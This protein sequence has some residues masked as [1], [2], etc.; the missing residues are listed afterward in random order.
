ML[1]EMGRDLELSKDEGEQLRKKF[2]KL[3]HQNNNY[4]D[5]MKY[6]QQLST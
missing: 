5:K 2:N 4:E 1:E 6:F 3:Y